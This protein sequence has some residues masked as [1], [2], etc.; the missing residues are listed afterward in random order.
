MSLQIGC[1]ENCRTIGRIRRVFGKW[2]KHNSSSTSWELIK[3]GASYFALTLTYFQGR[4]FH[5]IQDHSVNNKARILCLCLLNLY[6]ALFYSSIIKGTL[7]PT[8]R[9]ITF[10]NL[11]IPAYVALFLDPWGPYFH[12]LPESHILNLGDHH[13]PTNS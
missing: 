11:Y 2:V 7:Q 6:S 3:L 9:H 5:I 12:H 10:F 8:H 1:R 4:K 13:P